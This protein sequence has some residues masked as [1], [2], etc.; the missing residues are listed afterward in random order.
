MLR[1][2][3]WTDLTFDYFDVSAAIIREIEV[4]VEDLCSGVCSCTIHG[5]PLEVQLGAGHG[6][7]ELVL[8]EAAGLDVAS[9]MDGHVKEVIG[10]GGTLFGILNFIEFDTIRA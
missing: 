9:P 8:I 1:S 3:T 2:I 6:S 7:V 10:G 4:L 5:E